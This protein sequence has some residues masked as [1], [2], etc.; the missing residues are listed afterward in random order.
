LNDQRRTNARHRGRFAAPSPSPNPAIPP[1]PTGAPPTGNAEWLTRAAQVLPTEHF[2][3]Q[4][5]RAM[6]TS[7]SSARASLYLGSVSLSLV[8]FG[9]IGQALGDGAGFS[10]F[11]LVLFSTL[12]FLGIAT[13]ERVVQ[14][15]VEDLV[16]ARGI[17]RIRHFY[18]EFVPEAT[19][20]F[21]LSAHDDDAGAMENMSI[22]PS[23]WQRF[24]TM[25]GTIA[26]INSV[27]GAGVVGLAADFAGAPLAATM[28]TGGVAF[29]LAAAAH[30]RAAGTA[31]ARSGGQLEVR[32]PSPVR[33]GSH[34]T[35]VSGKAH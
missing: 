28:I 13:F 32:F 14:L 15:S 1:T 19:P 12:F 30:F 4:S 34:P 26:I 17:N 3:L 11:G 18:Q 27:V 21:I 20:Y 24:L 2:T 7:E 9:L 35:T 22:R 33:P 16:C 31:F 23:R 10:A 25:G 29:V 8:A 6:T 5:A